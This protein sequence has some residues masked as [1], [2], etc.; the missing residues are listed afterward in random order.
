LFLRD[1]SV[2]TTYRTLSSKAAQIQTKRINNNQPK[3]G[4]WWCSCSTDL[5]T[6]LRSLFYIWCQVQPWIWS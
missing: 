3:L 2:E 1:R 6:S 5:D 4:S